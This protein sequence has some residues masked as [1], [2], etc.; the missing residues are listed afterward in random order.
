MAR[1]ISILIF[2]FILFLALSVSA[3][4][5]GH[6]S[7]GHMGIHSDS[8]SHNMNQMTGHGSDH[9]YMDGYGNMDHKSHGT[10]MMDMGTAQQMME[11]Y[12]DNIAPGANHFQNFKDKGSYYCTDVFSHKGKL[13]D[14]LAI[15]K[16]TG[17]IHSL[18]DE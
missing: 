9:H 16:K 18:L 8:M 2:G 3:G 7:G 11:R 12:M 14:K 1:Q 13:M 17:N 6:V 4:M 5:G 10:Q 15:D